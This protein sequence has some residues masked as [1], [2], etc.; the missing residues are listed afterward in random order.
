MRFQGLNLN[1]LA[2]LQVLLDECSV[3]V[4]AR[5]MHL[6]QSAMSGVLNRLRKHY[7]DQI[8]EISGRK[9]V[10]TPFG[11]SLLSPLNDTLEHIERLVAATASFDPASSTRRFSVVTSD[12]MIETLLPY[13]MSVI[14]REAPLV[15]I[16][17]H[18]PSGKPGMLLNKGNVDIIITPE[19]YAGEPFLSERFCEED[20][21]VV[22]WKGNPAMHGPV[23]FATLNAFRHVGVQFPISLDLSIEG[24]SPSFAQLALQSAGCNCEVAVAVP[25]FATA[26]AAVIGT[27][28]ITVTH[29]RL[30]LRLADPDHHVVC[31]LPMP[32]QPLREALVYHPLRSQDAGL[33]WLKNILHSALAS[34]DSASGLVSEKTVE[35]E[36]A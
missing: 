5:K 6:S 9:M 15:S 16:E 32:V 26:F 12:Y 21:V 11:D 8:L 14:E 13:A 24:H 22:G 31:D 25:T 3:S 4:A 1:L 7:G 30:A 19:G 34:A 2:A 23:D 17:F 20:F 36:A 10:R 33:V 29:R 35:I 18:L 27:S 28:L